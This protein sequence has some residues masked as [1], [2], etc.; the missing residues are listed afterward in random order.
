MTA[1]APASNTMS[2][3]DAAVVV[4]A[5]GRPACAYSCGL[6]PPGWGAGAIVA[7][8]TDDPAAPR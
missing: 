3:S 1:P 4:D 5:R 8:A 6:G 7:V 2:T